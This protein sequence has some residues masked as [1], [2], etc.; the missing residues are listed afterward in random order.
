MGRIWSFVKT[1]S[2]SR[3]LLQED[4]FHQVP[5]NTEG[6]LMW[7]PIFVLI[8]HFRSEYLIILH[9]KRMSYSQMYEKY[10]A[11]SSFCTIRC[12]FLNYLV[13]LHWIWPQKP[14][15]FYYQFLHN[16]NKTWKIVYILM[17]LTFW[18]MSPLNFL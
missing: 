10:M 3:T 18:L 17:Y 1:F 11:T 5:S 9:P 13:I 4:H 14:S 8:I 2:L 6:F 7:A 15:Q 16:N 12:S